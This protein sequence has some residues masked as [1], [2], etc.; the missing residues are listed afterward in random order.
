MAEGITLQ[1]PALSSLF[2]WQYYGDDNQSVNENID[3][4]NDKPYPLYN[5]AAIQTINVDGVEL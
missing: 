5:F 4:L 1:T 2:N 3:A